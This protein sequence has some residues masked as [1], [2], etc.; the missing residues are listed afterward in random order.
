MTLEFSREGKLAELVPDHLLSDINRYEVLS[1]VDRKGE[2]YE[3]RRNVGVSRPRF[4]DLFITLFDHL[5]DLL[6]EL[7][8]NV[9]AFF[10]RS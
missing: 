6:K 7:L 1:V 5:H 3:L 8:I 2:A 9:W 4:Y 10:G